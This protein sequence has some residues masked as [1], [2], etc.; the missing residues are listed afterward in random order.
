VNCVRD[1]PVA[2]LYTRSSSEFQIVGVT[3]ASNTTGQQLLITVANPP[4]NTT[5]H[6]VYRQNPRIVDVFPLTH[7]IGYCPSQSHHNR[8]TVIRLRR[9]VL[10]SYIHCVSEKRSPFYILNNW[11][12]VVSRI[13]TFPDGHFSGKTIPGCFF[14]KT[15]RFP[16]RRFQDG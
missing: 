16:E 10:P 4:V 8:L 11:D 1:F 13:V 5:R 3:P 9:T 15:R 2:I 6:F 12:T 14:R 7:L